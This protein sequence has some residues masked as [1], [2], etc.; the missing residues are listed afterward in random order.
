MRRLFSSTRL[1]FLLSKEEEK[2]KAAETEYLKQLFENC[3]EAQLANKLALRFRKMVV[4]RK[5]DRLKQWIEDAIES[6]ENVLK[7]FAI[8][9][10]Q[11]YDAIYH[12]CSLEW[13]NG[14]VEGQI[15]R[16]KML[17]RQMYGRASH[18]LLKKRFLC[19]I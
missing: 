3:P 15:N 13:S 7:N 8:G 16:L 2:I 18:E 9:L 14:Q 11:D 1:G 19:P 17:K 4:H 10:K 5:A 6:G 12:A